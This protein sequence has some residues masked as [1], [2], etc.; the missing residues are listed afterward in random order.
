MTHPNRYRTLILAVLALALSSLACIFQKPYSI[1]LGIQS[2]DQCKGI[3][4]NIPFQEETS[5]ASSNEYTTSLYSDDG[6][7]THD[8]TISGRLFCSWE[9]PYQSQ[10]KV[11]TIRA[12]LVIYTIKDMGQAQAMFS[13]YSQDVT[14][15]PEYCHEDHDCTVAIESFS[16][17]R[18]YYVEKNV[19]GELQGTTLPSYHYGHLVRLI[20]GPDEYYVLDLYVDHPELA[21]GSDF[22]IDVVS[23]I[24]NNLL[25]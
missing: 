7:I 15:K 13:Q 22:V 12:N 9:K 18:N 2:T 4:S 25:Q 11:G 17:D 3:N 14:G 19:T 21:P 1:N 5:S 24:E 6:E 16:S 23:K 10:E 20:A 8:I